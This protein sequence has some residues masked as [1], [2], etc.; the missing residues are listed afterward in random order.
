MDFR[1][2]RIALANPADAARLRED[3][4][5]DRTEQANAR[6]RHAA[7]VRTERAGRSPARRRWGQA[8]GQDTAS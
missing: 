7:S 2:I 4:Q 1:R 8:P 3:D 6:S 5:R